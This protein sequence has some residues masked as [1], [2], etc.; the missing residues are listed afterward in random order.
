MATIMSLAG[1]CKAHLN[2]TTVF[3]ENWKAKSAC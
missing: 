1:L 2:L 3:L